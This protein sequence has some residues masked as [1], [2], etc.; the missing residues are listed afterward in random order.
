[1]SESLRK[2]AETIQA[3]KARLLSAQTRDNE[4][5][6]IVG[7]G[8]RFPGGA[9]SPASLWSLLSSGVDTVGEIPPE[10][11]DVDAYYDPDPAT[12][13]K[14]YTRA[15]AF[16][17]GV[18][19]FD[20][21]FFG[22]SPRET[23]A[24]D[25][26]HRLLLE[27]SWA[28]LEDAGIVPASLVDT[29]TGVFVGIGS[30]D[31]A[32]RGYATLEGTNWEDVS[33]YAGTGTDVSFSAGR[34]SYVLG[35]QGPSLALDT[36]CSSSLVALH[37]ACQSLRAS[38]CRVALAG[39]VSLNLWPLGY[40]FLSRSR[41]LAADGRCKTFS[42]QADGFGRG[43]GC[44]VLVVKRLSDAQADGDRIWAVVRGSAVAHD[45]P[46]SGLTAPNGT[47]QAQ[48][49]REALR[50]AGVRPEELHYVEAHGT[51]TQ[52]G[53]PIEVE[54]L[55]AVHRG[56]TEPLRIGSL[57]TNLGHLEAAAGVAGVM[58]TVLSMWHG[59]IPAHLHAEELNPNIAWDELPVRVTR[60]PEAWPSNDA[61][62]R[63]GVSAFGM[64]GTN[65]HVV[66]EG[67]PRE[68]RGAAVPT[69]NDALLVLSA[70]SEAALRAQAAQLA[71]HLSE[72]P[73]L[74]LMDVAHSLATTRSHFSHRLGIRAV[75]LGTAREALEAVAHGNQS[76]RVISGIARAA[77]PRLG[78][79]FTGQGSQ[80]AHMGRQLY[81][82]EPVFRAVIDRCTAVLEPSV[83]L[84]ELLFSGPEVDSPLDQTVFTQPALFALECALA[85]LWR[86]W[87]VEPSV[88]LGHSVGEYAAA[89]VAGVFSLEDGLR[90]VAARGRLMQALQA[91]GAMVS[92]QASE[93]R[94]APELVRNAG[95]VSLGAVNG[96]EQVV[97]S[98]EASAVLALAAA[99]ES[100]G[101]RTRRLPVSHAFHSSLMDPMLKD[102]ARVAE[103]VVYSRPQIPLVSNL[104]GKLGGEGI[105]RP[106]YWV[107]HA[108]EP[109]RFAEGVATFLAQ[110]VDACVELGPRPT[111][112]ALAAACAPD[113][114]VRWLSSLRP[115]LGERDAVLK[116]LGE[117]Y[118]AGL[119]IDWKRVLEGRR[120]DLPTYAF[121]RERHW[122][123]EPR[124][125]S[126]T[127]YETKWEVEGGE[128]KEGD[129]R[130]RWVVC[131]V[132]GGVAEA[133]RKRGGEVEEVE[134]GKSVEEALRQGARGLVCV[135]S[136]EGSEPTEQ[137]LAALQAAL[138]APT[139]V[140]V[141]AVTR[142]AVPA[143]SGE[144]C[145]P[146][147]TAVWG[148]GRAA[149]LEQPRHWGG[150]WDLPAGADEGALSALVAGL[151]GEGEEQTALRGGGVRYVPR[152]VAH[153]A[154]KTAALKLSG[155]A[156]VTGGL[157]GVG[158]EV[159]Q[160]AVKKGAERVVLV[161]RRGMKT[162]GAAEVVAK[163]RGVRR[164]GGSGRGGCLRQRRDEAAAGVAGGGAAVEG[165]IPR[166]GP[167]AG[168][169]TGEAGEGRAAG[170]FCGEGGGCGGVGR[171][172][173]RQGAGSLRVFFVGGVGV[174]SWD[175][176][177]VR[178]G[179][180]VRGRSG[181]E[182]KGGREV[183]GDGE[184]WAVGRGR[185]GQ[186]GGG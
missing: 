156:L 146:G 72:H 60:A 158:R 123:D 63:A 68:T 14:M 70:K 18:D 186:R 75:D 103:T 108:R 31:Y 26:R 136:G 24:L 128:R 85:V 43:E 1:M 57:K 28:A 166:G 180:C 74:E 77:P 174:G 71:A 30:S 59:Q 118:V 148:L 8:C 120:V 33:A 4:P 142:G 21:D 150:L 22:I 67:M 151:C 9:N 78:F 139:V 138:R 175:A 112:S 159:A 176:G 161:S 116:S 69:K 100:Q 39:G 105:A 92:V 55:A 182:E 79:L 107:R 40:V 106:E 53:D 61:P 99:L 88:L 80:Y 163:L 155:T 23:K 12:P 181:V 115:P 84:K 129:A 101:L 89:F 19:R 90:L 73:A 144:K 169:G 97:L 65:A 96:P 11:W 147:Q 15:G 114:K 44:G 102:F 162:E 86:S 29:K 91:P 52:L 122:I 141:H 111:L 3:L 49:I 27:T 178:G 126:G 145:E 113:S 165:G 133:L 5:I 25:P 56:R 34:L 16:L 131:G 93:A 13:G 173:G 164:R 35:L 87:G 64:S 47:S 110:K 125:E 81:E 121:Q 82:S 54:A 135:C 32:Y 177:R 46:S 37:L 157:G 2:A 143:V 48:V 149:S 58:K 172:A 168:G 184:F 153:A 6:A 50:V 83:S 10:R 171:A 185:D 41:A 45:G 62:R 109:V 127:L 51:G 66:L 130:G 134:E 154:G 124:R 7:M 140:R 183:R 76:V 117:L 132:A 160:W 42:A 36:A 152:V 38:E 179:E 170:S 94:V 98:G 17:Q 104:D 95:S 137:V 119:E 20:A 167:V